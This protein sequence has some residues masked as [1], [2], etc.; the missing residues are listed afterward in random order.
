MPMSSAEVSS[1][2]SRTSKPDGDLYVS[3]DE[4]SNRVVLFYSHSIAALALCEAYGMTQDANLREPAQ[5]ALDF[6]VA[7]A[8]SIT[9]RLA[10]YAPHQIGYV[11]D[12]LDDDGTQERRTG[13]PEGAGRYVRRIRQWLD[14]AQA[15]ES[16]PHLYCYNPYAP[17]TA[18]QR[19]GR[20]PT[21]TMTSVGLLMRLYSGWRR[22]NPTMGRGATT[23]SSSR[24]RRH[25]NQSPTR[26]VL[27]VLC[28]A[29]H[30]PHGWTVLERL[31]SPLHPLLVDAQIRE[32][33]WPAAGIR[34]TRC[35]TGGHRLPDGST[36]PP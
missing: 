36:S 26:H 32:D 1:F 27:L 30:V 16:Q 23:C 12:R 6:I 9:R 15:S 20:R 18:E 14:R 17:D 3:M 21:Q 7:V 35:R 11:G 5:K 25:A 19:G 24:R 22:D 4:E 29:G 2:W 28:H 8:E 13:E 34:I 33:R 10:L 31:E